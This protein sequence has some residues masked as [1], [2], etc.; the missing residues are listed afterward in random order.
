MLKKEGLKSTDIF[1]V[2]QEAKQLKG[3]VS[4]QNYYKSITEPTVVESQ[5]LDF[6][7]PF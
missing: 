4:S 7:K 2:E 6:S 1:D 5:T 3:F